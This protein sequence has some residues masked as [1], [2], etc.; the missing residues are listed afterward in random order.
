[1]QFLLLIKAIA[2][3]KA[4]HILSV[5]YNIN[6]IKVYLLSCIIYI[7]KVLERN[8]TFIINK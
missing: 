8:F 3:T 2:M 7:E 5:T 4:L 1:M 6:C